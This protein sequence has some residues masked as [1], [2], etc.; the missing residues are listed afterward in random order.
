MYSMT[1][2]LT[3]DHSIAEA[4]DSPR[5]MSSPRRGKGVI[6]A[7][8]RIPSAQGL[9]DE[10]LQSPPVPPLPPSD[11]EE[12]REERTAALSPEEA[13]YTL[14]ALVGEEMRLEQGALWRLKDL[15]GRQDMFGRDDEDE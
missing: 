8:T 5:L 11:D 1:G 3:L 6:Q 14:R 2:Y 7:R 10:R 4:E 12:Q 15:D 9:V 13:W